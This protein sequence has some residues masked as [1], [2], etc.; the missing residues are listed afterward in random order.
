MAVV[1]N[2]L[3]VKPPDDIGSDRTDLA[4]LWKAVAAVVNLVRA[5]FSGRL[6]EWHVDE[7]VDDVA[8]PILHNLRRKPIGWLPFRWEGT[9]W[10]ETNY[11]A[12][13]A[14]TLAPRTAAGTVVMSFVL[15]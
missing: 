7:P 2:P 9:V 5:F 11:E 14:D 15:F 3:P 10:P 4:R 13:T 12:W 8:T 6:I 1:P